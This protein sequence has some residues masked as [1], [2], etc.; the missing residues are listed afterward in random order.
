MSKVAI[1]RSLLA[2][3]I[4]TNQNCLE[5]KALFSDEILASL[6]NCQFGCSN[7]CWCQASL[8]K[9]SVVIFILD[10]T[11]AI[12]YILELTVTGWIQLRTKEENYAGSLSIFSHSYPQSANTQLQIQ[13]CNYK[14]A[15]THNY[16]YTIEIHKYK[17]R[18]LCWVSFNLPPN[19][20]RCR[21][22]RSSG[23]AK[24]SNPVRNH[25]SRQRQDLRNTERNLSLNLFRDKK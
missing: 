12:L 1:Y 18:K 13:Q 14:N 11:F 19:L 21:I 16:R 17:R 20:L 2:K 5:S 22:P 24:N 3:D 6:I 15:Q 8:E 9:D 7:E 23:G 4:E 25:F 10:E